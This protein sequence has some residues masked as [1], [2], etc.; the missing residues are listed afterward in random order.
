V[1][2]F[3]SLEITRPVSRGILG[4]LK[5]ILSKPK[6][7]VEPRECCGGQYASLCFDPGK[8]GPDWEKIRRLA[9]EYA[10]F[11]LAPEG[12]APPEDSGLRVYNPTSGF[13]RQVL[14]HTTCEMIA[15]TK[16]PMYRRVLGLID[17]DGDWADQLYPL[18]RHYTSVKVVTKNLSR[19]RFAADQMMEELGAPVLVGEQLSSLSDCV[20]VVAPGDFSSREDFRLPCPVLTGGVC[21]LRYRPLLV[22]KPEVGLPRFAGPPPPGI[23]EHLFAAA[24][25]ELCD[26]DGISLT[27]KRLLLGHKRSLPAEAAGEIMRLSGQRGYF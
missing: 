27:A 24:L 15:L 18:L 8:T 14:L 3:V 26:V 16:M 11:V 21:E 1:G 7:W 25:Y 2:V 22:E 12:L 19:Y 5:G 10:P 6:A 23:P 9:E 17:T 20:L 4:R 13:R